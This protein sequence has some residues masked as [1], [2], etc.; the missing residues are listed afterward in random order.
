MNFLNHLEQWLEEAN[1]RS[2]SIIAAK[3]EEIE[4]NIASPPPKEKS[5][6]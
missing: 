5:C 3:S 6:L 2:S 4:K 1:E